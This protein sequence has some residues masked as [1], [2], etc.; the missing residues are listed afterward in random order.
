MYLPRAIDVLKDPVDPLTFYREYVAQNIPV[1]IRN[2]TKNWKT[3]QWNN[4]YLR[5][6][7]GQKEVSVECTPKGKG[8]YVRKGKFVMP[9]KRQMKLTDFLD[10]METKSRAKGNLYISHQNSNFVSEFAPLHG[11]VE[12]HLSWATDAFG[13]LPEVTNIWM[14]DNKAFSSCHK[15]HYE[16]IYVVVAGEKHFTLLPPTDYP[17]LYE[18]RFPP[19][20][21]KQD[22][23]GKWRVYD[24]PHAT[25]NKV[26]WIAVDPDAPDLTKYPLFAHCKPYKVTVKAG[27]CLYLPS[28]W[29]HQVICGRL[30]L[31]DRFVELFFFLFQVS[32]TPDAEGRCIAINY[33]YDMRYDAKFNYRNFLANTWKLW[34]N[35]E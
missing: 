9:E 34:P 11:D 10:V 29:Y 35:K 33:W 17:F 24:E 15:D 12:S 21:F 23:S 14:G 13:C 25:A 5:K 18:E 22:T 28:L 26:P 16:N 1:V 6:A 7:M 8:D 32:Q 19:A 4:A 3:S 2:V 27:E 20:R 31:F 30:L